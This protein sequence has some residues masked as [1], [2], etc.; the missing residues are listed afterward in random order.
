MQAVDGEQ[1]EG[2]K[3]EV[4]NDPLV[5]EISSDVTVKK[6]SADVYGA[7]LITL[8][9]GIR[10][11]V[12]KTDYTPNQISMRA[13]SWGGSSLY[14][15]DEYLLVANTPM[16]SLGGWGSF[17][18]SQLQKRLAGIQASVDPTVLDRTEGLSG[19]CVKKDLET[20]MQLTYLC[21]TA[22]HRDDETFQSAM[23][24]L[25]D[26]LKNQ[27]MN[28]RTALQD[29]IASVVYNNNVRRK[30]LRVED[31]DRI[32]YDR[33][34]EIYGQRFA[35]AADFE[36]YFVGDVDADTLRPMLCKYLGALPVQKGHEKYR[37]ISSRIRR[38]EH[39]CLFEKEQDT[40]NSLTVFLYHQKMKSNLRNN[41]QLSMLEQAMQML[42]S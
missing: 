22:P 25:R 1:I 35:N 23:D 18:A 34:L 2:L 26:Q 28:P 21:F 13:S 24:R 37:S 20:M 42:Y 16:V 8:S 17:T 38:G 29:S 5:P 14:P 19:S 10:V 41:I 3:E 15:D 40:P 32:D 11:H 6:E 36:F 9:N 31:V 30:R 33:I 4:N 7:Q 27:D 12:L 39:T